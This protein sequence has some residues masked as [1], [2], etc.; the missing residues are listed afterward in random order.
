MA[1]VGQLTAAAVPLAVAAGYFVEGFLQLALSG[2]HP[3]AMLL[4]QCQPVGKHA[5]AVV[6]ALVAATA[7]AVAP[8]AGAGVELCYTG[9]CSY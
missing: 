5:A 4:M 1:A 7:S 8:A 9:R 6:A 2:C 3:D